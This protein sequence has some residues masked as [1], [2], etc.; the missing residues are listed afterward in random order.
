MSQPL[1]LEIQTK[2]KEYPFTRP[3]IKDIP[4]RPPLDAATRRQS[5]RTKLR[6]RMTP[7]NSDF[8][9]MRE[10][11]EEVTWLKNHIEAQFWSEFESLINSRKSQGESVLID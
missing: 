11:P 9:F 5:I 6:S 10:H 3:S 7:S 4:K 2:L 8:E 1:P